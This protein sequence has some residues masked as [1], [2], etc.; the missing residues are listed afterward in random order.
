MEVIAGEVQES[1]AVRIGRLVPDGQNTS[2][3]SRDNH[4]VDISGLIECWMRKSE[5][6]VGTKSSDWDEGAAHTSIPTRNRAAAGTCKQGCRHA[7][8][9]HSTHAAE[10]ECGQRDAFQLKLNIRRPVRLR[11]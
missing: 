4:E 1:Q 10:G 7:L 9:A 6:G 11:M 2:G 5:W 3:R 8:G